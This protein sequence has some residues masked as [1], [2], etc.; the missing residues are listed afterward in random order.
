MKTKSAKAKGRRLQQE[1]R[2]AILAA[3]THLTERDVRSTS[4]GCYG[5]DV[6]LSEA[7]KA[8][9]P[10]SVECK[11]HSRMAIYSLFL[12]SV[13]NSTPDTTP[14]LVVKQDRSVPLAVITLDHFMELTKNAGNVRN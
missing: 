3:F 4:M 12:Q 10:Y 1:V 7:G 14:L 9:F 2:D 5:T 11:S 8:S 13:A 6:L